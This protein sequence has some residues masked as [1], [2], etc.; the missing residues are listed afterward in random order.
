MS[1]SV[2]E[3]ALR[4]EIVRSFQIHAFEL[5]KEAVKLCVKLFL[6]HDQETRKKWMNKMIEMLKKQTLQSSLI[7]EE[8]I[9][10]T[11]RQCKSKGPT[12]AGRLLNVFD[13][14]SL[15]PY[16][17]YP[18]MKKMI[19]RKEKTSLAAETF[20]FSHATRQ[21]FLL[22]Q[23]RAERC[24][25]LKNIKFT[26]CE[27][28][29][30]N[31]TIDSVVVLGML[32]QPKADCFHVEDL[33]GS[34][35]VA[36]KPK[37][38]QNPGTKFHEA[39]FHEHS[40]AIFE[41]MFE[42]GVLTVNEVAQVPME[43]AEITRKELSSNENWFGGED[44][45][46]FRCSDRLRTAL[47]KQ[48]ET[49]I[50]FLS[51][52]FFDDKMVMKALFELLKGYKDQPPVAIILCGNF[53]SRPRQTDTIDLLD[54]GFRWLANQLSS[55]KNEYAKTQF[56]F[57]PGPDD[58]FVD[59]VLPRPHLPSLLFKHVS[60]IISCTFASNP[61]R[62]Q[63]ASLEIVVFRANMIKKMCRHAINEIVDE[64]TIPKRFAKSVLSQAHLCPLPPNIVPV[65]PD[66]SHSLALHPL[67]DLL[68]TADHFDSF[69]EKFNGIGT[70]VSN[71]GSF[72]SNDYAF[73]VYYPSQ[74]RVEASQIPESV[75][76]DK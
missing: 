66:F 30:L 11:F 42:N 9:K 7:S 45:I 60:P 53:C 62:I 22:V 43:S 52:V 50:I 72:S 19:L 29:G 75:L 47:Q 36:F 2:D 51:E 49:S 6:D 27:I 23:Q 15:P 48:E 16:D 55:L 26:T 64:T 38:E 21:R 57:V 8:L 56:I 18:E 73:Q 14:F 25:S 40:I 28:L 31:K 12:D 39:L 65:L 41:G 37:N 24:A 74:N 13:A 4:R 17:Y 33:T 76:V 1:S 67:P 20:S 69:I 71:P 59:T 5:K 58:P 61:C 54:R 10:D 32:T 44:K 68:I 34:I 3:N 63:F 35:E 46:A 70:I